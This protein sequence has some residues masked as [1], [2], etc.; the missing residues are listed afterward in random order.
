MTKKGKTKGREKDKNCYLKFKNERDFSNELSLIL[1]RMQLE[2]ITSFI[3][4][5]ILIPLFSITESLPC[6]VTHECDTNSVC[7]THPKYPFNPYCKC[8]AHYEKSNDGACVGKIFFFG[9]IS[10]CCSTFTFFNSAIRMR[11]IRPELN[12][13][14]NI[15]FIMKLPSTIPS[16]SCRINATIISDR[17]AWRM[18]NGNK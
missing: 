6:P 11:P 1:V 14:E 10:S 12:K 9:T 13:F 17:N 18:H 3:Q 15:V 4:C 7:I 16:T 2:S 5:N 8:K